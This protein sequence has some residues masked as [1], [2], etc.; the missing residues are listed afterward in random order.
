MTLSGDGDWGS[1]AMSTAGD[2][3]FWGMGWG[4]DMLSV[5]SRGCECKG[6]LPAA[7]RDGEGGSSLPTS[8]VE[9]WVHCGTGTGIGPG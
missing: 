2:W 8:I 4:T 3:V 9:D 1:L 7:S 6:S 5:A